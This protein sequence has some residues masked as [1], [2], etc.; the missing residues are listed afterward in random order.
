MVEY[1]YGNKIEVEKEQQRKRELMSY[2]PKMLGTV[3]ETKYVLW[4]DDKPKLSNC[5]GGKIVETSFPVDTLKECG[6]FKVRNGNS[7]I[8]IPG[9]ENN[10]K[11]IGFDN[12]KECAVS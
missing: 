3:D 4:D 10:G 5:F 12:K 6:E 1:F 2:F 9:F 11:N 7:K 8:G